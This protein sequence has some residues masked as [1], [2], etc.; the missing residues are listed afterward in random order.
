MKIPV[1]IC[2]ICACA[3]GQS[4][5]ISAPVFTGSGLNDAAS[6]GV[7]SL[8]PTNATYTATI[9]ATGTPDHFTWAKNSGTA[10]APVAITG[11]TCVPT[12]GTGWQTLQDGVKI[13]WLASTGHTL[14]ASWTISAN[15][16]GSLYGTNTIQR[17]AGARMRTGEDKAREIISVT[18]FG[19]FADGTSAGNV[20]T[21][22]R[23]AFQAA[24]DAVGAAGGGAIFIPFASQPPY[25]NRPLCY[26]IKINGAGEGV[27]THSNTT[28]YSDSKSTCVQWMNGPTGQ[29]F[30]TDPLAATTNVHWKN[31]T[32][33]GNRANA[34]GIIGDGG[35]FSIACQGCSN[36]SIE[37]MLLPN[38]Y[39][40]AIGIFCYG[41]P[42]I[43]PGDGFLIKNVIA[44]NARRNGGSQACGL[45]TTIDGGAFTHANG[46]NPEA[47]FDLEPFIS[48]QRNTGF[49]VINK[50]EFSGNN[51]HGLFLNYTG[52]ADPAANWSVDANAHDNCVTAR[53]TAACAEIFAVAFTAQ[54]GLTITGD[55]KATNSGAPWSIATSYV[56]GNI[57]SY[58][59]GDFKALTNNTGLIPTT[60]S[61][62]WTGA[63]TAAILLNGGFTDVNISANARGAALGLYLG[64][65]QTNVAL[66]PGTL[67][68]S[69]FDISPDVPT[70]NLVM[71]GVILAH[72]NNGNGI[73][74]GLYVMPIPVT[75]S[76]LDFRTNGVCSSPN[77]FVPGITCGLNVTVNNST[78]SPYVALND[79]A[80]HLGSVVISAGAGNVLQVG[81][82]SADPACLKTAT[83]CHVTVNA[84]GKT[85]VS[86][87][88]EV[89]ANSQIDGNE[90]VIGSLN[91][92][93]SLTV[94][95][96]L[97]TAPITGLTGDVTASG[98]GNVPATLSSTGVSAGTYGDS[99]HIPQITVDAKGRLSLVTSVATPGGAT[100]TDTYVTGCSLSAGTD[101]ACKTVAA[102]VCT[103]SITVIT[104][105]SIG[106]ST[107]SAVFT[108]GLHQ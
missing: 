41:S 74:S 78:S 9:S 82:D 68:G 106:C 19:A 37:D 55:Y 14:A 30:Y 42:Q 5:T 88:L 60:H 24:S 10:S 59:G 21:D 90:A 79:G 107:G 72:G 29:V 70:V 86:N 104:S 98:P 69:N 17:G 61:S 13:C 96:A 8:L 3:F 92:T 83:T 57:V 67:S 32:I 63:E 34:T 94:G 28:W 101:T 48:S 103:A 25:L 35:N 64:N 39:T 71:G 12:T 43:I 66:G 84:A 56:I 11:G 53:F 99:T 36:S 91:V 50:T 87:D 44:D 73:Q 47:G 62:D 45:N 38:A 16:R 31:F 54:R 22:Q 105:V 40:D 80:G 65:A 85:D 49:R 26:M 23:A 93:G 95:G 6:S 2:V 18:D 27:L 100:V 15:A 20:G 52:V 76:W 102:G 89:H 77:D 97:V 51:S 108:N 58:N 33:D 1:L 46:T 75:G 7:F 4:V 81:T